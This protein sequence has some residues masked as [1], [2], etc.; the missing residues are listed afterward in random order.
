MNTAV[1]EKYVWKLKEKILCRDD[2][3]LN[4]YYEARIINILEEYGITYYKI[5]YF[6][7]FIF[8][9]YK[10]IKL[11]IFRFLRNFFRIGQNDT[12]D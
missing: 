6:V 5:H 1:G 10:I 7:G 3:L 8:F 12:I 4:V 2:P 11:C 9:I